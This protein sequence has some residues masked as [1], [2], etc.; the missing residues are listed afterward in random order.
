M[1]PASSM[2]GGAAAA[3]QEGPRERGR[4][5]TGAVVGPGLGP[6]GAGEAAAL[7]ATSCPLPPRGRVRCPPG[8]AQ[9]SALLAARDTCPQTRS[10]RSPRHG[11]GGPRR[12][13]EAV[14]LSRLPPGEPR[15]TGWGRG[16]GA[17]SGGLGRSEVAG[18]KPEVSQRKQLACLLGKP[19][20]KKNQECLTCLEN[21][22]NL[23][24]TAA[25]M[26][27]FPLMLPDQRFA[28]FPPS[29]FFCGRR[30]LLTREAEEQAALRGQRA[31]VWLRGQ[32]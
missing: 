18:G 12:E 15:G 24:H 5:G 21:L 7:S 20:S 13:P 27:V 29:P 31:H 28:L 17:L 25:P 9:G 2:R 16:D 10:R 30:C 22:V 4:S 1:A 19:P 26:Y 3:P 8:D 14:V 11:P 32:V 6:G 23:A